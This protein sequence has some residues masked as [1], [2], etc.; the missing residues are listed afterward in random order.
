MVRPEHVALAA[1]GGPVPSRHNAVDGLVRE[2]TYLGAGLR[3]DLDLPDGRR[4][5]ARTGTRNVHVPQVGETVV[6]HWDPDNAL[7]VTD[8]VVPAAPTAAA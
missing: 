1:V 5:I 8:D 7:A 4:I 6:A 2:V 3:V